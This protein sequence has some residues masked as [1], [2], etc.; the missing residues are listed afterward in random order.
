MN[1][2]NYD[3]SRDADAVK[4]MYCEAGWGDYK[5]CDRAYVE[6][7]RSLVA[8]IDDSAAAL[9]VSSFGDIRYLDE[10]L[11]LA[12]IGAVI[13]DLTARK[14][15]LSSQLTARRV[16]LDARDGTAVSVLG[17]FEDGYY[18]RLGFGT[19]SYDHWVHF[20]PSNLKIDVEPR[21]PRRLTENDWEMM[22]Q[23]RL[24]RC[25]FHG[26]CNFYTP[27]YTMAE[28]AEEGGF[29][30]GYFSD[31]GELTHHLFMGGRGKE[32][33]PFVVRWLSYQTTEQLFELLA[34]IKSFG[35]Q[36]HVISLW[37]SPELS[38]QDLLARPFYHRRL[39]VGS[40]RQQGRRRRLVADAHLRSR[41]MPGEDEAA[42]R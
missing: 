8:L 35:D 32:E 39:T 26:G 41:K 27:Q 40:P 19:G 16:M 15:R 36:F 23:N 42:G 7:E 10:T 3:P 31:D 14:Q 9:A 33:G 13:T 18:N 5:D 38:L 34:L 4:R 37:E 6:A 28:A 12:C 20:S 1:Y 25:R 29:G 22:H 21:T 11:P 2:R 30:F 17:A 24:A